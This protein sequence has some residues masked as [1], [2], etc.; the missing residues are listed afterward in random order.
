[1]VDASALNTR[2][3]F[4]ISSQCP[5]PRRSKYSPHCIHCFFFV[6]NE[7]RQERAKRSLLIAQS[8][9]AAPFP[10]RYRTQNLALNVLIRHIKTACLGR[11]TQR[12]HALNTTDLCIIRA[13]NTANT[14]K[15]VVSQ[16]L[17]L[18]GVQ[19]TPGL[20]PSYRSS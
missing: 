17:T 7:I 14:N 2:P 4:G 16:C 15:C 3:A 5:R 11:A 9:S 8:C 12:N 13:V 10:E 18:H 19:S 1:M 20:L 6:T